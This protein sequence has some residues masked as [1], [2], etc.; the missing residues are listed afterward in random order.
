MFPQPWSREA[1]ATL[2][3]PSLRL[4]RFLL[5]C[6]EG[7]EWDPPFLSFASDESCDADILH[8]PAFNPLI[9]TRQAR[10]FMIFDD[11]HQTAFVLLI[12]PIQQRTQSYTKYWFETAFKRERWQSRLTPSGKAW[13]ETEIPH[14]AQLLKF[15]PK[16]HAIALQQRWCSSKR[17]HSCIHKTQRAKNA[18]NCC[19]D[20]N[21]LGR[22]LL[23]PELVSNMFIHYYQFWASFS[24]HKA[25]IWNSIL[26]WDEIKSLNRLQLSCIQSSPVNLWAK[27]SLTHTHT[28]TKRRYSTE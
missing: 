10:I 25:Q 5:I 22:L 26:L 15:H 28:H 3:P 17:S 24:S 1:K 6:S 13:E 23:K 8:P 7:V 19:S 16:S 4:L 2:S 14:V 20:P 18:R 9:P 21:C 11:K 27:A 12:V